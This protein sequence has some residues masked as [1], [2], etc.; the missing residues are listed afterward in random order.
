MNDGKN[1]TSPAVELR[2]V[3]KRYDGKVILDG[4]D[5]AAARGEFLALVGPSGSG[6]STLLRMVSGI[7]APDAGEVCLQGENVTRLP[8]YRRP[9]HTVFQNYAL[10]PHLTVAGNVDFP[11]SVAGVPRPERERRVHQALGWVKLDEFAARRVDQLSGGQQQRVALARALVKEPQC[12][13]LDEPLAALDVHLRGHTLQLLQELQARLGVTYLYVTHDREEA[14]RA[15]HR[16]GVLRAGRLEQVGTPEEVYFRPRTLFVAEFLGPINWLAGVAEVL[17]GKPGVRLRGGPW[18]PVPPPFVGAVRLGVRPAHVRLAPDG[19]LPLRVAGR[20]FRG[21][22][23]LL[24][25][26][27]ENGV[28]LHAEVRADAALP[29][30]GA[31]VRAGWASEAAHVFE[32]VSGR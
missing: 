28:S 22:A 10:F 2:G 19:W 13:L 29:A 18:V 7:D 30:V 4:I 6:K 3:S 27:G 11:L 26:E 12:V 8:A 21:D 32:D 23:V 9:V 5:L 31:E 16:V 15:A 1:L 24:R 25:L 17:D 14:L 20:E